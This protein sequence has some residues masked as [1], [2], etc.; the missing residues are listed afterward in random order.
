MDIV[1]KT[2][3]ITGGA[4]RIGNEICRAFAEA[5][6]HVVIHCNKSSHQAVV[7]L[8]EL[9]GTAA[10]HSIYQCD[11]SDFETIPELFQ[12]VGS[13]DVLINNASTFVMGSLADEDFDDAQFQFDINY[14]APVKLMRAF[15]SQS[16][17]SGCIIN[18]LD[19]RI[20]KVD[21]IGGSYPIS[22]KALHDATLQ[23]AVQWAPRI[24][25][26]GIAPGPVIAPEGLKSSIHQARID[27]TPLKRRI[28]LQDLTDSCLFLAKNESITGNIIYVDC[29]EHLI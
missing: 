18:L 14:W 13:I 26:N 8:E 15:Q 2:V 1:N 25:V 9:G 4:L 23:A 12:Q 16:I 27:A 11:L 22:K 20:D 21:P 3:L 17:D 6:A 10:G 29:G 5:G 28:S 24:R 7:L 19:Q